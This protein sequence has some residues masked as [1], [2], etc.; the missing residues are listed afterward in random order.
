MPPGTESLEP[1][2]VT[3]G[4][5]VRTGGASVATGGRW[6]PTHRADAVWGRLLRLYVRA[7]VVAVAI[8]LFL[9]L[10]GMEFSGRQWA[11]LLIGVT[12]GVPLYVTPDVL[13]MRSQF[14][15]VRRALGRL[16]DGLEL[17]PDTHAEGLVRA[18]NLPYLSFLRINFLHGPL[19]TL[20][21]FLV[22]GISNAFFDAGFQTWQTLFLAF[23]ILVFASPAHAIYEFFAISR[24]MA[25]TMERLWASG[26]ALS[27]ESQALIRSTRLRRKLFYLSVFTAAVPLGFLAWSAVYKVRLIMTGLGMEPGLEELWPLLS[28]SGGLLAVSISLVLI[29]AY[30]LASDVTQ[31]AAA[32]VEGMRRVREGDL[33]IELRVSG[34]DEFADLYLG[35]NHMTS[36]LRDELRIHGI[37]HE[38]AGVMDLNTLI[39][40]IMSAATDLLDAERSTLFL[41]DEETDE[42]WSRFAEGLTQREIRFR[43]DSGIASHVLKSGTIANIA[44]PYSDARF[45]PEIDRETGFTT[46]SILCAPIVHKRGTRIGVAQVLNK[47]G[48]VFSSTDEARLQSFA[49]QISASLENARLFENILEMK[50]YSDSILRS[51][52]DGI[53]T[54]DRERKIVTANLSACR[55]LNATEREMIG[56]DAS[57][58]FGRANAWVLDCVD[59]VEETGEPDLAVD[60]DLTGDRG[61][62]SVNLRTAPLLDGHDERIGFLLAFE[63]M[64]GEKRLK[65]TMSRYM[66]KEVADQLLESGAEA[67]TGRNQKISVL[68]SDIRGFTTLSEEL[69]ARETVAMLNE[70]FEIMVDVVHRHG[71][72]LDKYI[73]DAIMALFGAPFAGSEDADHAVATANEMMVRLTELNDA[74]EQRGEKP[75]GIGI[76]ICTGEVVAGNIGSPKRLDYTAV[77]DHVNVAARLE[78]ATKHYGVSILVS[79]FTV[80]AL[81]KP[82]A[83]REIDVTRVK[84][85]NRPVRLYEA[86][87]HV[88][89]GGA[90]GA[91]FLDS[92]AEA[93]ETMR[94]REWARAIELF[95]VTL[96]M[97]PDDGPARLHLERCRGY[98]KQPPPADWDG[99]WT[100]SSK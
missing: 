72:I 55:I 29:I 42:L 70:Y 64:T 40:R 25:P 34:T 98:E 3:T 47:R 14:A 78:S 19:A 99:V 44:D 39:S 88:V 15:P 54:L 36:E 91:Q 63:D 31:G 53:L 66:S 96:R 100:M 23:S 89:A 41:Y 5:V 75:I 33:D 60:A 9:C 50:A 95:E 28:W 17:D 86:V 77:G 73:G 27:A 46:T 16:D 45:N 94:R 93:M 11:C 6:G 68:F 30:L 81:T 10:C 56:R 18:L 26:D 24:V 57:A 32:L 48:G 49:A 51:T 67:L 76:G 22:F 61:E 21:V 97:R 79:E 74:R 7:S 65:T 13:V 2:D 43:A 90:V 12:L 35:F 1:F 38:L 58:F 82:H 8:T 80:A 69:G 62:S 85:K 37:T 84:G 4:V 71:G 92:Y 59:A 83:L 87:D 20:E 52:R